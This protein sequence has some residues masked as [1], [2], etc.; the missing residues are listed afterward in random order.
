MRYLP[1]RDASN[2]PGRTSALTV[3][4]SHRQRTAATCDDD[5]AASRCTWPADV[6]PVE[7]FD[8]I[9]QYLCRDD[10][11][12]M[13]LVNR[14]FE[15]KVAISLFHTSVV[16]FNTELYDMIE[17]GTKSKAHKEGKVYK[18]HGL[19]VFEGFGPH[20]KRF[21]MT[22]EVSEN[23]LLL[24][25]SVKR[26]YDSVDSYHGPYDWPIGEYARFDDRAGLERTADEIS[27]MKAAFSKL[28][29]VKE[30]ALSVDSGLGWLSGPD[31][32]VHSQ[33]FNAPPPVFGKLHQASDRRSQAALALP[34]DAETDHTDHSILYTTRNVNPNAST[35]TANM[36][37]PKELRKEQKEWLL[38]TEWAQQAFLE[39]YTLA[40]IDNP[41]FTR[42]TSLRIAK[43]SSRFINK[44]STR[45]F[46]AAL[47]AL[48]NV[49]V[50]VSPDWR[51]VAKNDAGSA[52]M[53]PVNPSEA[54]C[55]FYDLLRQHIATLQLKTLNI[56]WVRD[57]G[58]E[59]ARGIFARNKHLLPAPVSKLA[60][61]LASTGG[62]ALVFKGVEQLTLT[63]CWITPPMLQGLVESHADHR[64]KKL[65]LDSVSLT[66][67]PRLM[68]QPPFP[69]LPGMPGYIPPP[70]IHW[71][72]GH[73]ESSWPAL[74]NELSPGPVFADFLPAPQEGEATH[75]SRPQ[76]NLQTIECISCGYARL[77]NDH[78]FE[79]DTLEPDWFFG[80]KSR[81]W[82]RSRR[83]AL[84]P[85][86]METRD[87]YVGR[88]VQQMERRELNALLFAWGM[89]RGWSDT[90][91]AEEVQYDGYLRGGSGRFSGVI[92]RS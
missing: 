43:L 52:E 28:T 13:R 7:L 92:Q 57:S 65:T 70:I 76:T 63:N 85:L 71:S 5:D 21:G 4:A 90:A 14:E 32:S 6:L 35:T 20:I 44:L 61:A 23:Q 87:E 16:P 46:W 3:L 74:L 38:E 34:A 67:H 30:L 78:T 9:T 62:F 50:H 17:E 89:T 48:E 64:L 29:I 81:S 42:I 59:H 12:A 33:I 11:E 36:I 72:E 18:G 8:A 19:R 80:P 75:P 39:S 47:P 10:M 31:K 1:L 88:I 53:T 27:R 58:G 22:F 26:E 84:K 2:A 86:M 49:L 66:A 68:N 54:V 77:E 24:Q 79:Q 40:V 82:F 73:R 41:G 15:R 55:S 60:R 25:P 37:T 83:I 51:T 69:P 91:K 45:A 56:G